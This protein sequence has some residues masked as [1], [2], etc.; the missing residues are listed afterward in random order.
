MVRAGGIEKR[1]LVVS[2][3]L[4]IAGVVGVAFLTRPVI[5]AVLGAR[6]A[7]ASRYVVALGL[8]ATFRGVA[9]VYNNY[10]SAQAQ[11]R[12][13]QHAAF[14]LAG[15]NLL[16]NF[17]LIPA[18]GATGAAWASALALAVNLGF[19]VLLVKRYE[20]ERRHAVCRHDDPAAASNGG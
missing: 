5:S 13:L 11:G 8:A 17:A 14:V 9:S 15:A 20:R 2:W 16:F 4:G 6:Y 3:G 12:R 19:Y 18:F 1:W 10:L 7:D